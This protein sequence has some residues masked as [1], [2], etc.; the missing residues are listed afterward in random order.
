MGGLTQ[1]PWLVIPA[2]TKLGPEAFW[3]NSGR[4][5]VATQTSESYYILRPEVVESYMYLWRQTHDPIYREWGWE[6]VMVSG[7]A[8]GEG[9]EPVAGALENSQ[10]GSKPKR[11]GKPGWHLAKV[12][13]AKGQGLAA[14]PRVPSRP[15]AGQELVKSVLSAQQCQQTERAERRAAVR[16]GPAHAWSLLSDAEAWTGDFRFLL[17]NRSGLPAHLPPLPEASPALGSPL[18]GLCSPNPLPSLGQVSKAGVGIPEGSWMD[19]KLSLLFSPGPTALGGTDLVGRATLPEHVLSW[20][21]GP[22]QAHALCFIGQNPSAFLKTL[23]L[24]L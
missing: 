17:S 20:G 1:T 16:G 4:E 3:F 8:Q 15:G 9:G 12:E 6:V 18:S 7:G 24:D 21:V 22:A 23:V 11:K 10:P 2:D 13:S 14:E 5:A 19:A